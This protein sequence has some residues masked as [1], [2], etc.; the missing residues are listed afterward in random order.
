MRLRN[1][2]LPTIVFLCCLLNQASAQDSTIYSKLY[3]L[4][5]KFFSKLNKKSQ[6]IESKLSKQT[7]KYLDRLARQ[8][9]KLQRKLH[10]KD[11]AAAKE[12]FGDVD[13]R[14]AKLKSGLSDQNVYSGRLDSMQTALSFL[15]RPLS[16]KS[17]AAQTQVQSVMGNYN[18][19]QEKINSTA[20]IKQQLKE[21]Q[22]YLKQHLQKFGLAKEF[23][24]YQKEVYYYRAQVD[25][26]KRMW[27]DPSK[28]E[29]K[30]LQLANKVPAF[31]SFF[32][33]HS[34]L[35]SLFRVPDETRSMESLRGLQRRENV[36]SLVNQR[37]TAG[38]PGAQQMVQQNVAGA[39]AQLHQ[40]KEKLSQLGN[41]GDIEMPGFKPNNQ[42]TKSFLNRLEFGTNIQT[43]K[44][45]YYF[46]AVSDIGLSVGYKLNDKSSIG[47]GA[48]YKLG[49]GSRWNNIQLTHE[50]VGL[51]SFFDW[52]LKGNFYLSGGYEQNYNAAFNRIAQLKEESAWRK[53]ALIGVSKKYSIRKKLK[54][55]MQLL[56]DFLHSQQVPA[57]QA[58]QFRLGY[59]FK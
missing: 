59:I 32:N 14:Y 5:D 34:Y 38:G 48:S 12:I 41:G 58:I 45:R 51:R 46:P 44:A 55:N 25:E 29:A 39:Q 16:N 35:A 17:A 40:L 20:A 33:K 10:R 43:Q 50:G 1:A 37:I 3:N 49:L 31:K 27:E 2:L 4:P 26:Y 19:L 21:R 53:S 15:Q 56:Y 28:L 47:V 52:R 8:E 54:G 9:K 22:Q 7:D 42:R 36:Q 13:A 24:K 23:K 57:T 30:L 6:D 11:S 18:K